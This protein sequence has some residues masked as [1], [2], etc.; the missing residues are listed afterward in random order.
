MAGRP[1]PWRDGRIEAVDVDRQIIA[2]ARLRNLLLLVIRH[3]LG[4]QRCIGAGAN[5]Y[6]A[7]PLDVEKLLSLVRVWMPK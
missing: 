6:M 5:D 3:S 1:H 2:S 7:K 4:R